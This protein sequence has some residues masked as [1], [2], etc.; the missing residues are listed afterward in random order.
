[1]RTDFDL[2]ID[3]ITFLDA[4]PILISKLI[5]QMRSEFD[6][7]TQ[8]HDL[9]TIEIVHNTTTTILWTISN[10]TSIFKENCNRSSS[11]KIE[12]EIIN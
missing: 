6:I 3:Q 11:S 9:V 5:N 2:K 8:I 4:N 12:F 7:Q 1:M 10:Q